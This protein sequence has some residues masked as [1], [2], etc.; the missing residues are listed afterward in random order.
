MLSYFIW[1]NIDCRAMGCKLSGPAPIIRPEERVKH[2]TIPGRSGDLTLLEDAHVYNSYIQTVTIKVKGADRVREINE[3]LSG[4][5]YVTF[6]GEP[7]KRQSA[8]IIGA[9]T[10]NRH[11]RNLDLWEG[12]VQFYCQPLKLIRQDEVITVTSSGTAVINRGDVKAKPLWKLTA[13]GSSATVASGGKSMTVTGLTSGSVYFI[14]SDAMEVYNADRSAI[15]TGNST[16]GFPVLDIGSNSV[17]GSGWSKLEIER[18][19]RFL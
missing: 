12:E 5:D 15:L 8:R 2:I 7:D 10:L 17:T 13:S 3:W 14:D 16:G 4:S 6:S 1:K 11:S 9:I 19:E 18:R